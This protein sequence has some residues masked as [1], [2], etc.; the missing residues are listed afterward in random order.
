V[1]VGASEGGGWLVLW[2]L[3]LSSS[4][5]SHSDSSRSRQ[6]LASRALP[7]DASGSP[8]VTDLGPILARV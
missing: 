2:L 7:A 1:A 3:L 6:S 4:S 5:S 8:P